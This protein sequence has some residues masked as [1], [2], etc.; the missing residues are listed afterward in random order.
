MNVY[1]GGVLHR[2]V[3]ALAKRRRTGRAERRTGP[4]ALG[5][6]GR[7]DSDLV[8]VVMIKI[9]VV[10]M[11]MIVM[12]VMME[13]MVMLIRGRTL[14][15]ASPSCSRRRSSRPCRPATLARF[16]TLQCI[17]KICHFGA[18]CKNKWKTF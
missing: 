9:L 14:T 2:V 1:L 8:M 6:G 17:G 10:M 16:A 5:T 11:V 12:I 18:R 3:A 13:R 4:A 7:E 15:R